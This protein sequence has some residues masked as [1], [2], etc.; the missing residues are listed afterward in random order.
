MTY[1]LMKVRVAEEL[2]AANCE[3]VHLLLDFRPAVAERT[4]SGS[5]LLAELESRGFLSQNN[6]NR[7][8][9]ILQQIPAMPAA[10]IVERYKRENH[11]R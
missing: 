7:L 9:E 4:R 11:I 2:T 3:T 1:G 6:V 8:I 10:N 5:S